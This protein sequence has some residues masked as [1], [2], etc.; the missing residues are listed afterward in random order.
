MVCDR[1][2][3]SVNNILNKLDIKFK[4]ISLGEYRVSVLNSSLNLKLRSELINVGFDLI[5]D[6][7]KIISSKIKAILIEI[8]NKDLI[9]N[10]HISSILLENFN[11]SYNH[12]CK[13]FKFSENISI[14][15]YFLKL[16][17]E[18][19]KE[20]LSYKELTIKEISYKSNYNSISHLSN[21]FKKET[22]YSPSNFKKNNF[23]REGLNI[24]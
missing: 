2:I 14:E 17:I 10:K 3:F 12:L 15:K 11:Y 20:Y 13:V 18:K 22:G 4:F 9:E 16:K 19:I 6:K 21:H 7:Q 8:F 23:E 1:C 24:K 5:Y